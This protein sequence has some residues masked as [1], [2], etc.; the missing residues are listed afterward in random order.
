MGWNAYINKEIPLSKIY[1]IWEGKVKT[2]QI[3][4]IAVDFFFIFL[5]MIQP[6]E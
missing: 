4:C 5:V 2:L 1:G 3:N 6:V